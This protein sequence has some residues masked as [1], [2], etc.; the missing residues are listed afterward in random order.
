LLNTQI[1]DVL[2][3]NF[4][5]KLELVAAPKLASES[6]WL[7]SDLGTHLK[8]HRGISDFNV[9]TSCKYSDI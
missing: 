1:S 7:F 6:A 3:G 5:S 9:R 4:T 2:D 8:S